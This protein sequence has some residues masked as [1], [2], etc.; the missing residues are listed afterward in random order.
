MPEITVFQD[1]FILFHNKLTLEAYSGNKIPQET[2]LNV[3][4][5]K[6]SFIGLVDNGGSTDSADIYVDYL[7]CEY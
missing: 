3:Y 5:L 4:W 1:I 2:A 6:F 7:R